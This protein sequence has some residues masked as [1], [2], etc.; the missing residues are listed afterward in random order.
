[1]KGTTK[2]RKNLEYLSYGIG[3]TTGKTIKFYL[4]E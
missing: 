1:M 3:F 4:I 2:P